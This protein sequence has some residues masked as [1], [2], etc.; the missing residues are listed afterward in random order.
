M[1]DIIG[2][3]VRFE[4]KRL[5]DEYNKK[6]LDMK[7]NRIC[8]RGISAYDDKVIYGYLCQSRGDTSEYSP[9]WWICSN[10]YDIGTVFNARS[11]DD[12]F[13][14]CTVKQESIQQWDY[15]NNHWVNIFN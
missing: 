14:W 4:D 6:V 9:I 5:T 7:K 12:T 13:V 3:P 15:K 2:K 8:F 10:R 11:C 1:S